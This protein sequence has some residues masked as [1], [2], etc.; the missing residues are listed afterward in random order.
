MEVDETFTQASNHKE[1]FRDKPTLL[2]GPESAKAKGKAAFQRFI[3]RPEEW[4]TPPK[5]IKKQAT[6]NYVAKNLFS[7]VVPPKKLTKVTKT[8]ISVPSI[9]KND[10][11]NLALKNFTQKKS[12]Q[13]IN[14]QCCNI[15]DIHFFSVDTPQNIQRNEAI[16]PEEKEYVRLERDCNINGNSN[17]KLDFSEIENILAS[18]S[19]VFNGLKRKFDELQKDFDVAIRNHEEKVEYV[20]NLI[21]NTSSHATKKSAKETVNFVVP[22]PIN[23]ED[24]GLEKAIIMYNSMRRNVQLTTPLMNRNA[25]TTPKNIKMEKKL[26]SRKLQKQC[27]ELVDT[28]IK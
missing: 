14:S 22:S 5:V 18:D 4:D 23:I 25:L 13:E 2:E 12:L 24:K 3:I 26:L 11:E 19:E 27:L 15:S 20:R 7:K 8:K 1:V 28:P 6:T 16:S 10:C 21:K 9:K 17:M